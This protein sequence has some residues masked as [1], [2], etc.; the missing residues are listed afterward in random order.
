MPAATLVIFWLPALMP[1]LPIAGELA[2]ALPEASTKLKPLSSIFVP[3]AMTLFTFKSLFKVT[4]TPFASALVVILL[5]PLTLI[6]S[7]NF[8]TP[9]VPESPAKVKPL[10]STTS[11]AATPLAMS[12]LVA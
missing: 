7:P 10:L 11:F 6:L 12:S 5:S 9:V 1:V 8:L 3:L 4:K 2:T